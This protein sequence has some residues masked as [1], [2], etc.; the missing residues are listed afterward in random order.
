MAKTPE[1]ILAKKKAVLQRKIT[2]L[3]VKITKIDARKLTAENKR[4]ALVIAPLTP[5]QTQASRQIA[6]D[7]LTAKINRMRDLQVEA[8]T[9]LIALQ[10]ELSQL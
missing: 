5:R 2:A 10:L 1:E 7:K 8:S 9:K 3:S 4:E 6:L